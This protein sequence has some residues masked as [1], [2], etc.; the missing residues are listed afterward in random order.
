MERREFL[1]T[2]ARCRAPR[3]SWALSAWA[4]T[5]PRFY[6]KATLVDSA[7]APL[8]VRTIADETN[9]VFQFPFAGTPCF[10]LKLARP[11]EAS[12]TPQ[13]R[14]WIDVRVA[15]WGGAGPLDRRVF[16]DLRAQARLSDARRFIHPLSATALDELRRAGH[17]LLRRAQRL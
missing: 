14:R 4:D 1:G 11:V 17:P 15:R 3:A 5:A 2:C 13:A 12:A 6:D 7:G 8:R 10:L 9:Y 16:G